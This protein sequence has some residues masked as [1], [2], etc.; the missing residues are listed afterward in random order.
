MNA[1]TTLSSNI[2]NNLNN[3]PVSR[4]YRLGWLAWLG[5]NKT[6]Y[7]LAQSGAEKL[8]ASRQQWVS[9]LVEKGQSVEEQAQSGVDF[10]KE[11]IKPK[12]ENA[13]SSVSTARSKLFT[14]ADDAAA[15]QIEVL[16]EA[17][18]NLT[19]TVGELTEKVNA[20]RARAAKKPAAQDTA[21]EVK[22]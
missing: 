17:I 21:T 22:S 16:T 18:A 5:A 20:P 4:A 7:N 12:F 15:D 9:D 2:G 11:Y 19:K 8:N 10:A 6:A 13:R 14:P 3:N 1:F